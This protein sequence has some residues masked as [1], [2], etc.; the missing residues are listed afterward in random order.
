MRLRIE[1][2]GSSIY[3]ICSDEKGPGS[4]LNCQALSDFSAPMCAI[5]ESTEQN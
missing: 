4:T 3:Y 1:F 2:G 5:E